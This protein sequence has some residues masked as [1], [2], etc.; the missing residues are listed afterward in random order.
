MDALRISEAHFIGNSMG[1]NAITRFAID[2]PDRVKGLMLTG[3]E[4][5]VETLE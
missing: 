3:G 1:S 4:P 5:I 2:H